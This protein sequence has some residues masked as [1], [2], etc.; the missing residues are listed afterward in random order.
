M[1]KLITLCLVSLMGF[2]ASAQTT[3]TDFTATDC[4]GTSHTLFSEL[5]AGKVVVLVWVMPC[6]GCIADALT[7]QTEVQN[8]LATN[9]GKVLYYLADDF[10]TTS[11]QTLNSW[12]STNG[13]T[14][15]TVFKS[16]A[17][18]MSDYGDNGMPKI[19]VIGGSS[20]T[21]YYNAKAPNISSN[22]IK[23]GIDAALAAINTNT[24]T[25][26]GIKENNSNIGEIVL[27]PNPS[28][29]STNLKISL[30]QT[31]KVVVEILN[32]LG[33]AVKQGYAGELTKGTHSITITT[34]DLASGNYFIKI[35]DGVAVK[36]EKIMVV[37]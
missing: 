21:V 37:H 32:Q 5:D 10:G 26:T 6:G 8:A 25:T 29:N 1:K 15:P 9:P 16:S 30:T 36:K 28:N 3:A 22:G 14:L 7:A 13:I 18:K 20:H 33:Q 4:G 31:R 35:T 19:V 11:C 17:I 34:S 24:N 12:C 23:G 27:Y 2:F